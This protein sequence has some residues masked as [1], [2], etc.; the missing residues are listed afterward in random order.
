MLAMI[1]LSAW[2]ARGQKDAADYYVGGR[3]LPWWALGLSVMATQSSA[4]SFIGIPAFVALKEGGGLSW[5]SYEL[6]V[7]LA[8]LLVMVILF[9]AFHR[10]KII[11]VYEYLEHRFDARTRK[12]LSGVFLL[13]RGLATGVGL[14][15]AALVL[16]LVLGTSTSVAIVIMGVGTVAYDV[17][18]GMK[19]VVIS[20]VIQLVVLFAGLL[21]CIAVAS[22]MG[23][24]S[25]WLASEPDRLQ[26]FDPRLGIGDGAT[27]PFWGF[28][29]GGLVLYMSYYGAD[30]S[31]VQRALS[32]AS[33]EDGRKLYLLS[34][35]TRLPLTLLYMTLGLF[36]GA[37]AAQTPELAKLI[38]AD[39]LNQ[40]VPQF[41]GNYLPNGIRGIVVAALLAAAMSSLDSAL[42]GLSAATMRD[43][44]APGRDLSD[45]A[46][47]RIS[48]L[49]TFAWGTA[50]TLF[51][52][53]VGDLEDTVVEGINKIGAFFYGPLLMAFVMGIVSRRVT[54][55]ATLLGVAIGLATNVAL[56]LAFGSD[57][58][59]TWWNVTGAVAAAGST[60]ILSILQVGH[61]GDTDTA[62]IEWPRTESIFLL[63]Y[64]ALILLLIL[65]AKEIVNAFL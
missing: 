27:M 37:A 51:A 48:K 18:G 60:S 53:V 29:C 54:G 12:L 9:P 13:S 43:F 20:D 56:Y 14:Y 4:N 64:T 2:L 23:D 33:P 19:A 45:Q 30:Q 52:F 62:R 58:H 57:I 6:A 41:I 65:F 59:W 44:I 5:L 35:V 8:M 46:A 31:Q 3:K 63:G 17:M 11:S 10:Q 34:G 61:A 39:N 36:L 7:P 50:I 49:T 22:S 24:L 32:A 55:L 1:A 26:A 25:S 40:L 42:N 47:L 28:L 38:P 21:A 16:Q 15:A